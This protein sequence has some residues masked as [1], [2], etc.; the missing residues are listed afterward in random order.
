[1]VGGEL[2]LSSTLYGDENFLSGPKVNLT[3]DS[4]FLKKFTI[5]E[6]ISF[7]EGAVHACL[8]H[9]NMLGVKSFAGTS[10]VECRELFNPLVLLVY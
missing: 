2:E 7:V 6:I 8:Q 9:I 3:L 4:N 10:P 5:Q 1:M